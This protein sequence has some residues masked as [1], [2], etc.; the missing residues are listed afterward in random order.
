MT[1]HRCKEKR[2]A[3]ISYRS[4]DGPRCTHHDARWAI[5]RLHGELGRH[6]L[7]HRHRAGSGKRIRHPHRVGANGIKML[8]SPAHLAPSAGANAPAGG[9]PPFYVHTASPLVPI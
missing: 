3:D 4:G 5:H 6:L 8:T 9:A 2:R 1:I 7:Q